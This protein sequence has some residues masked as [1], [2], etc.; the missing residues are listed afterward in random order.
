MT[1]RNGKVQGQNLDVLKTNVWN[2]AENGEEKLSPNDFYFQATWKILKRILFW[3]PKFSKFFQSYLL[4]ISNVPHFPT[5]SKF[6]I[7]SKMANF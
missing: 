1:L 3:Q 2:F 5:K 7:I 4:T 6:V